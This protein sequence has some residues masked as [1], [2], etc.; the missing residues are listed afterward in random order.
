MLEQFQISDRFQ[1]NV[2]ATQ[3]AE[4]LQYCKMEN[5]PL[6]QLLHIDR[7]RGTMKLRIKSTACHLLQRVDKGLNVM[8]NRLSAE[9]EP[10]GM[11]QRRLA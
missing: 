3:K 8:I 5:V 4:L 1:M 11:I 7:P 2:A 10:S 9:V 6:A